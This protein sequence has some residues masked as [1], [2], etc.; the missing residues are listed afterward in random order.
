MFT[1]AGCAAASS[2]PYVGVGNTSLAY[3]NECDYPGYVGVCDPYA[4]GPYF[5]YWDGFVWRRGFR[6]DFDRH[7]DFNRFHVP[8]QGFDERFRGGFHIGHGGF[9]GR[10]GFGGSHGHG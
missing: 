9:G 3:A 10:T 6:R 8:R 2:S 1:L 5:Y 7:H 4:Y